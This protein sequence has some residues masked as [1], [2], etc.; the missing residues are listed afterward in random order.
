MKTLLLLNRF[1]WYQ[2]WPLKAAVF[3]LT[4][5]A[6]CFPHPGVLVRHIRHW[7]DPNALIDADSPALAPLIAELEPKMAA[8][9]EPAQALKTV[10]Q[11]VYKKIPYE[12]DWNTW[13]TADY[14]P[15]VE[16]A[17]SMGR[18]DCDG[19]AVVAASLLTRFGFESQIVTD[20]SHCWVKTDRGD[21]MAPGS[22]NAIVGEHGGLR[23]NYAALAELPR[24]L[25]YGIAVFPF[26]R[27][28]IIVLVGWYLML[29]SRGG[30][31]CGLC[32]LVFMVNGLLLLRAGGREY[33]HPSWLLQWAGLANFGLG[34][35]ALAVF[36]AINARR[37]AP[38]DV[39]V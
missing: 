10:E 18:E 34:G 20:F 5:L 38:A 7:Q 22:P 1:R 19:R 35:L 16:E 29:R 37:W 36:G 2:R 26:G 17:I 33:L 30:K 13:G 9:M 32:A 6:V 27:E 39:I 28:M 11:F 21:T 25:A 31:V 12:W 15:T 3:G 24:A 4:V 14:M 8:P 23:V